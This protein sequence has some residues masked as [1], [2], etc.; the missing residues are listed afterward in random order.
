MSKYPKY[1]NKV[2]L[3]KQMVGGHD[4]TV[5][6][7]RQGNKYLM[8]EKFEMKMPEPKLDD[9]PLPTTAITSMMMRK[10]L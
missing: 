4:Y 3:T 10:L 2:A 8:L 6:Y 9:T 5:L 7:D 1:L